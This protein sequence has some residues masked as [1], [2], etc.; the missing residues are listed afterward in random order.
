MTDKITKSN[1]KPLQVFGKDLGDILLNATALEVSTVIVEDLTPTR[2]IPH[3]V[4]RDLYPISNAYLEKQGVEAGLRSRYLN[5]RRK[6]ELEYA[7]LLSDPNSE[8]YDADLVGNV[9]QNLPI[10]TNSS[11]ELDKIKTLLPPPDEILLVQ[12]LLK[13]SSF[14]RSLR[15]LHE[16]KIALDYR[17]KK[18]QSGEIPHEE[19]LYAQTTIH[20][21]GNIINRYAEDILNHP[22]RDLILQL[23]HQS[24]ESGE[25][26]WRRLFGLVLDLM[27]RLK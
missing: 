1:N 11:L 8:F 21:E 13:N 20:L 25:R 7:L 15:G 6:L 14:L 4:Y 16:T 3:E 19:I 18:L 2:F 24:V 23:H 5:L 12:K 26:L 27:G 22:Q 10:L 9:K 17:H